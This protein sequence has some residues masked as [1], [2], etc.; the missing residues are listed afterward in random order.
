MTAATREDQTIKDIM[1]QANAL[2]H[3]IRR[4]HPEILGDE[5]RLKKGI[6][7]GSVEDIYWHV[8]RYTALRDVVRRLIK[9]RNSIPRGEI[10]ET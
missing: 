2:G 1:R 8:G 6:E 3:W 9:D 4:E 10:G 7:R 5:H